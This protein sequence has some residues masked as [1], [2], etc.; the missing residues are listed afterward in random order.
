[1]SIFAG[2]FGMLKQ[3]KPTIRLGALLLEGLDS[4]GEVEL[5]RVFWRELKAQVGWLQ[6]AGTLK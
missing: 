1:M 4:G 3:R 2:Y 5:D 6:D